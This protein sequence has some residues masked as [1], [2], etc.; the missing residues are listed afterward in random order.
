M[1]GGFR[2]LS[3]PMMIEPVKP[4]DPQVLGGQRSDPTILGGRTQLFRPGS[5]RGCSAPVKVEELVPMVTSPRSFQI[6]IGSFIQLGR[7]RGERPLADLI[8]SVERTNHL[9]LT[10]SKGIRIHKFG[11]VHM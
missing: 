11:S 1:S 7:P 10:F 4:Q 6:Q 8:S 9:T 5:F 2:M 3:L